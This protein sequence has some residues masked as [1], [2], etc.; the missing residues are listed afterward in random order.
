MV[1]Q[2]RYSQTWSSILKYLKRELGTGVT[3]LELSDDEIVEGLEEDVL[4]LF[5]QYSPHRKHTWLSSVNQVVRSKAGQ[6]TWLYK[7]PIEE[8]E[9]IIDIYEAMPNVIGEYLDEFGTEAVDLTSADNMI[10]VVISNAYMDASK[11]LGVQN[12]WTFY[13]PDLLEFDKEITRAVVIYDVPHSTPKTVR[14]DMYNTT[15]KPLCLGT[16]QRWLVAKRS[17]F[18]NVTTPF[19]QINLNWQKLE[20]DS[21]THIQDAM[22]KLEL[23]PPDKLIE[24]A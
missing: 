21:Q 23:M 14:S 12:T 9:T 6:P 8:G 18:E 2:S 17:K 11:S 19:G 10:D 7:I 3:L 15:F 16:V 5:S 22:Q 20:T 24:V 4:A 1:Q 13:P